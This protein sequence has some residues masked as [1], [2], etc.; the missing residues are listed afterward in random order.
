MFQIPNLKIDNTDEWYDNIQELHSRIKKHL[1]TCIS[2]DDLITEHKDMI[3]QSLN[4]KLSYHLNN[5]LQEEISKIIKNITK[6]EYIEW[7][8]YSVNTIMFSINSLL[9][10]LNSI[11][12]LTS[13]TSSELI[14]V[15][16][17]TITYYLHD[18]HNK[19][20]ILDSIICNEN[21]GISYDEDS[22]ESDDTL[23]SCDE[24]DSISHNT[25]SSYS[26]TMSD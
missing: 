19:D 7:V 21:D 23:S 6:N 5:Y 8:K 25:S 10:V 15:I 24:E 17:K 26:D 20:G 12:K 22:D 14:Q 16:Y 13:F 3:C 9:I 1:S 4:I 18:E 2:D 11:N